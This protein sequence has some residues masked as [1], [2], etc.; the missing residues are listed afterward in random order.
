GHYLNIEDAVGLTNV[1]AGQV[2]VDE[3][4]QQRGRSSLWVLPSGSLPP[5]PS[6]LLGSRAMADLLQHLSSRYDR[7][8][9][10]TPPL[11][12]VTDAAVVAAQA[13]GVIF[14]TRSGGT[15]SAQIGKAIGALRVVGAHVL[16]SVLTMQRIKRG[17]G[18]YYP[19]YRAGTATT[20]TAPAAPRS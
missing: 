20:A 3:V 18:D 17:D 11:L 19:Y 9:I 2:R 6:E 7:I 10:D 13:D 12:A 4:A 5:N 15:S 8:I 1:L 14:V 16:G